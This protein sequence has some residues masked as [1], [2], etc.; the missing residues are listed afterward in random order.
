MP[1]DRLLPSDPFARRHL[2][3]SP[4]DAHAMLRT[5]G[6]ESMEQLVAETVPASILHK[7]SLRLS[8]AAS[9]EGRG[10]REV[11]EALRAIATENRVLKSHIGMGYYGT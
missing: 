5:I 4:A 2:G 6:A 8:G 3:P 1:N 9:G 11:L 7:E 10:E